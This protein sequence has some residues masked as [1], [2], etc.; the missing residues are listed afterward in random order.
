HE[1]H[2]DR[3]RAREGRAIGAVVVVE[4]QRHLGRRRVAQ[5]LV[6]LQEQRELVGRPRR[7]GGARRGG[8]FKNRAVIIAKVGPVAPGGVGLVSGGADEG[9]VVPR[10]GVGHHRVPT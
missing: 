2:G 10:R 3:Q 9:V 7:R 4:R 5:V 6:V 1:G 8:R